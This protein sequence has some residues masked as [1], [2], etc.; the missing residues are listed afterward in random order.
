ME[1][2]EKKAKKIAILNYKGGVGKTTTAVNL[3]DALHLLKKK[4]L[5]V[6]I[7]AQRNSTLILDNKHE[8]EQS[9]GTLYD[10][11]TSDN[12]ESMTVYDHNGGVDFIAGDIRIANIEGVLANSNTI[13]ELILK[14]ILTVVEPHYDYILIDCPPNHGLMT[15][16]ALYA[17]DSI[18]IPIDSQIMA[19]DGLN[20]IISTFSEIKRT[21]MN[22]NL[23]IEGYLLTRFRANQSSSKGVL[24]F[25]K[26]TTG[27]VFNARIRE[28]TTVGQAPGRRMTIFEYD[29]KCAGAEDYMQLAKELIKK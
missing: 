9:G 21:G 2:K 6:D 24:N 22:D 10:I 5:L 17:A 4:V 15:K 20:D 23:K 3:A 7:D 11:I 13:K 1:K 16:M 18:I 27:D 29:N 19:L 28:N 26:D 25:L 14:R 12:L 8:V